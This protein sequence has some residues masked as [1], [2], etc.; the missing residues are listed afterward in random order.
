[1][2][3]LKPHLESPS[4]SLCKPD[5]TVEW[6]NCYHRTEV[7]A[8]PGMRTHPW[9]QPISKTEKNTWQFASILIKA[10]F[11][12]MFFPT[13]G[14]PSSPCYCCFFTHLGFSTLPFFMPLFSSFIFQSLPYRSPYQKRFLQ[15]WFVHVPVFFTNDMAPSN[16]FA[17]YTSVST[18]F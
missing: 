15:Q 14:F 11:K 18:I 13:A 7:S 9:C 3:N 10:T 8:E 17:S 6:A 2:K 4:F 12:D 1:M 5:E 16:P